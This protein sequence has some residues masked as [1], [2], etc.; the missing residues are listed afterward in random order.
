MESFLRLGIEID[1]DKSFPGIAGYRREAECLFLEIK[2][3]FLIRN[4]GQ[5]SFEVISPAMKLTGKVLTAPALVPY[6]LIAAM[7]T[8]V[9]KSTY[10]T[11]FAPDD[12]D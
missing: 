8:H 4:K 12:E 10:A 1:K 6:E 5:L 9:V 3:I 11:V 2:E 7:G